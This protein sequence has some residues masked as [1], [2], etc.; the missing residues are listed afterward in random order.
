[1]RMMLQSQVE[2]VAIGKH[3]SVDLAEHAV[4]EAEEKKLAG[5]LKRK[6][7]EREEEDEE[8]SGAGGGGWGNDALMQ[9]IRRGVEAK[10]SERDGPKVTTKEVVNQRTGRKERRIEGG[11]KKVE[12]E[13]I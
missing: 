4:R 1:M 7:V 13:E 5:R 6:Q 12:V 11:G 2:E 8:D 9:V 10:F 3:G